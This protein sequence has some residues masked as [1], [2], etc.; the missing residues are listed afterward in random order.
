MLIKVQFT[1]YYYTT[2]NISVYERGA[3]SQQTETYQVT[4]KKD[5]AKASEDRAQ[6]RPWTPSGSWD[7]AVGTTSQEVV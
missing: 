6:S 1:N 4:T 2:N 5:T 7:T 3:W